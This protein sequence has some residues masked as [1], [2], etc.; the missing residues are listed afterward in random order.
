MRSTRRAGLLALALLLV[1]SVAGC[2]LKTQEQTTPPEPKTKPKPPVV[3]EQATETLF[4]E[5][6]DFIDG[7]AW[8]QR[9]GDIWEAIDGNGK[10]LVSLASGEVPTTDFSKGV[11]VVTY[12]VTPD[13]N[14]GENL[15]EAIRVI[16]KDGETVFPKAGDAQLYSLTGFLNGYTA[17]ETAISTAETHETR[18]GLINSTGAWVVEPSAEFSARNSGY[19]MEYGMLKADYKGSI[20]FDTNKGAFW[21]PTASKGYGSDTYDTDVAKLVEPYVFHDG[22]VFL[23]ISGDQVTLPLS[24]IDLA[25]VGF[26]RELP[27][28]TE[29][30][31]DGGRA[32]YGEN[33][34]VA[35]DLSKYN[36]AFPAGNF[37][38]GYLA[39]VLSNGAQRFYTILDKT[40]KQM[41]EPVKGDGIQDYSKGLALVD[42]TPQNQND[43]GSFYI[44]KSGATVISGIQAGFPFAENGLARVRMD[45]VET[46][47]KTG[48]NFI[49]T[50]G[51]IAF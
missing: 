44:D 51:S 35:F 31:Y 50:D 26:K 40:G 16:N 22:M 36:D 30:N 32:F 14:K 8:V 19:E 1:I 28:D 38:D 12:P 46:G 7:V 15:S 17:V 45:G 24:G 18:Q 29:G 33:K 41:F 20:F 5:A 42:P 27:H 9:Q 39:I 23:S 11:A 34:Q 6:H 25:L 3:Q 43:N 10:A 47:L 2:A 21:S 13:P 49:K 4:A 48:Y 37:S